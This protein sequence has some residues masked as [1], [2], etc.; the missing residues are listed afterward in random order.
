M[1]KRM[2]ERTDEWQLDL[3]LEGLLEE[4]PSG[5]KW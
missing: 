4:E 5:E 2:E 3:N 1:P